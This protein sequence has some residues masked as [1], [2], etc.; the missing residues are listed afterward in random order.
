M[1]SGNMFCIPSLGTLSCYYQLMMI[2]TFL[3]PKFPDAS[4][5]LT[6]EASPSKDSGQDA[7]LTLSCPQPIR[8]CTAWPLLPFLNS[9]HPAVSPCLPPQVTLQCS[10]ATLASTHSH[11]RA[12]AQAVPGILV[13]VLPHS[14]ISV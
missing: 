3:K 4:L 13:P 10:L 11:L 2:G 9:C 1:F 7:V 8:F 5:R 12:F 6:W 14:Q